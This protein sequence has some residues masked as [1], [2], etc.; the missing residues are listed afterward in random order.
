VKE[1]V[2]AKAPSKSTIE[3]S[4]T[5]ALDAADTAATVTEEFNGIKEQFEVVNIQAKRIYQSVLI[6]FVSSIIA[7]CVSGIAAFTIYFKSLSELDTSNRMAI[8]SIAIFTERVGALETAMA[9]IE[10]NTKNQETIQNTLDT[11]QDAALKASDDVA[12]ADQRYNQAIKIGVTETERLI[13]QFTT[14]TLSKLS[15]QVSEDTAELRSLVA[16]MQKLAEVSPDEAPSQAPE[17]KPEIDISTPVE[18]DKL[19]ELKVKFD[20]MLLLQKEIAAKLL[21]ME[22]K[23]RTPVKTSKA[24]KKPAQTKKAENPLKFP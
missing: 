21:E 14:S 12:S 20:E 3:E 18:V 16:E 15:D 13:N 11:L 4:I 9:T 8:E 10:T 22:R 23:A 24:T 19:D 6:I 1:S 17:M 5:V 7:A 2:M